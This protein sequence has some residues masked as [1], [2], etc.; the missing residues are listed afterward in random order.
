[1][2]PLFSRNANA[3][4]RG[5]LLLVGLLAVAVPL[6]LMGWVRTPYAR[7]V[8]RPLE[9]PVEFDHRHHV[10]DDRIDCRYC[11]WP[12]ER[13]PMAGVPSSDLCMNCHSQILNDS[14]LLAPV[15]QSV[16]EDRPIPWVR[17]H[18]LPDFVY[19]DHAS[20]VSAG[21]GCETCHG[22][23]D[24]MARVY[25]VAPLTM[26]WCLDCHRNPEPRLRPPERVTAM[27][28]REG[29]DDADAGTGPGAAGRAGQGPPSRPPVDPGTDCTTCHR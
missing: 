17:V 5:A 7:G 13:S 3:I 6:A 9:Q 1:M 2:D 20:H 15:R 14:P 16:D 21:V 24:R 11:H 23:V 29:A 12:V 27:G 25:Q 10:R 22:R 19:F 4:F 26:G 18:R 8:G 28:Y